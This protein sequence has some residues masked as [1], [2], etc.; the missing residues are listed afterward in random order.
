[1]TWEPLANLRGSGNELL[2]EYHDA[3]G[4]RVYKWMEGE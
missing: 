1:M 3:K 2:G 4:L